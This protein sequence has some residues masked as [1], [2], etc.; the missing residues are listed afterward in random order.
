MPG[1]IR[2]EG[3]MEFSTPT[4]VIGDSTLGSRSNEPRP[5]RVNRFRNCFPVYIVIC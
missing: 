5:G 2:V 1:I 3:G 4:T